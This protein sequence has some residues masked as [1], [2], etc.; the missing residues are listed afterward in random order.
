VQLSLTNG[1]KFT[2]IASNTS[3]RNKYIQSATM[4]GK[5]LK[6]PWFSHADIVNGGTLVLNMGPK[7]NKSWGVGND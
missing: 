4:N 5:V 2:I 3:A 1:K 7:P 6:G